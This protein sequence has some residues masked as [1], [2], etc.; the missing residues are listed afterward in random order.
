MGDDSPTSF[1]EIASDYNEDGIVDVIDIV[2]II[3]VI[4]ER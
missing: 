2:L 3:N 4:M 1:E